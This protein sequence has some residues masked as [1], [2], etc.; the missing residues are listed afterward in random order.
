MTRTLLLLPLLAACGEPLPC[1]TDDLAV[2]EV[3]ALVDD[4]LWLGA[5]ATWQSAGEGLQITTALSQGWRLN[6]VATRTEGGFFVGD[7]LDGLPVEVSLSGEAGAALAYP[8]FG[9]TMSSRDH[10]SGGSL[11]LLSLDDGALSACFEFSALGPNGGVVEFTGGRLV[12]AED[13]VNSD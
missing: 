8:E 1:E 7:A 3:E 10:P 9:N 11:T 6:L 2:G 13:V 12:A 4:Q 5:E